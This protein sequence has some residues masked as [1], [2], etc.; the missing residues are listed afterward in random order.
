MDLFRSEIEYF[1]G[2]EWHITDGHILA[3]EY[4]RSTQIMSACLA[5][6]RITLF[7]TPSTENKGLA[8]SSI[9]LP[10][11]TLTCFRWLNSR[12][13]VASSGEGVLRKFNIMTL[14]C[15]ACLHHNSGISSL[16]TDGA[17]VFSGSLDGQMSIWDIRQK[18]SV[19]TV[20][21]AARRWT[22]PVLGIAIN[23]QYI[24]SFTPERGTLWLWDTRKFSKRVAKLETKTHISSILFIR[25]N[26]YAQGSTGVVVAS[27][28]LKLSRQFCTQSNA[29]QCSQRIL[30]FVPC[31]ETLM[32]CRKDSLSFSD[33]LAPNV[34]TV[35][36]KDVNGIISTGT[37]RLFTF[38][39]S[40]RITEG[41]LRMIRYER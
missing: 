30:E 16:E 23:S 6:G 36:I 3:A 29:L 5:D 39:T 37:S 25:N 33:I 9:Q 26:L 32:W 15:N 11:Q 27:E 22:Q 10:E 21:H 28:S 4:N 14:E 31:Y 7:K 2:K 40:G 19:G 18:A 12:E 8:S 1:K 24:Y 13:F 34:K 35:R 41:R 38:D 17:T 20:V